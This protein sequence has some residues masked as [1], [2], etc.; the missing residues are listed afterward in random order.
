MNNQETKPSAPAESGK[1]D[2]EKQITEKKFRKPV[3]FIIGAAVLA[4]L[5]FLGAEFLLKSFTHESTDD[6]FLDTHFVSIAAKVAGWV[7]AVHPQDNQLVKQGDLLIEIDPRDFEAKLA[8]KKSA[9]SASEANAEA[10]RASYDLIRA[11]VETAKATAKQSQ[12]EADAEK[13][14]AERTAADLKRSE[15]LKQR[16]VVSAQEYDT[17]KASAENAEANFQAKQA[18]LASDES[19]VNEARAQLVAAKPLVEMAQAQFQQSQADEKIAELDLSYTKVVAP[20]DGRVTTK[21]VTR[22]NYVQVGQNLL[23]L[24]PTNLWVTANF[25]ETQLQKIRPG[26]PVEIEIDSVVDKTFRGHVDSIQSG[27]GARF[28]L[29]P[30]ENAVGNYVKVVQR[31]PVK[32]LFDE[33]PQAEHALGPGMSVV[34]IVQT[35]TTTVPKIILIFG[36]II[37]SALI[38]IFFWWMTRPKNKTS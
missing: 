8:Q 4:L 13:A 2:A 38:A 32:I 9:A 11:R 36:A 19:K 16:N 24:V 17:A 25:K 14:N 20:V 29:L 6:A 30:P 15:D 12:A 3:V 1:P 22:G 26:Q 7:T 10:I 23:A 21:H 35:S 27:S 31:V 28:S 37:L 18:Q 34:P 33:Y 5:L